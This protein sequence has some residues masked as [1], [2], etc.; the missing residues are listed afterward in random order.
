MDNDFYGKT[1]EKIT[2]LEKNLELI[3]KTDIQKVLK[4][5]NKNNTY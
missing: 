2:K 1:M 3:D 5:T 4:K